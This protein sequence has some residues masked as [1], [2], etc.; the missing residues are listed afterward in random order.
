VPG[1][2]LGTP[3]Y[4]S[5]EQCRGDEQLDHRSDVYALGVVLY[6]ML[7]GE[8]PF[9]GD[10]LFQ[11]LF[12]QT[13]ATPRPPRELRPEITD[14][15]QTVVQI[16]LEK[17]P[18]QRFTGMDA[19]REAL[20]SDGPLR[21][22][23]ETIAATVQAK[24][25]APALAKASA[26]AE[27]KVEPEL[28]PEQIKDQ[29]QRVGSRLARI[30]VERIHKDKLVLPNLPTVA[31]ECIALLDDPDGGMT[32]V[33]M[34]IGRDP[35]VA[36]QVLRRARSAMMGGGERVRTIEHAVARLGARQLRALLI[37]LS[38]RRL[39]E[40]RDPA[41]RR[42]TRN[43]WEHSV[44]VAV[45]ARALARRR[46]DVDS[47]VA[48]LAGLLH[49]VGKP[50]AAALLLEAERSTAARDGAWLGSAA[51]LG[52]IDECHREVGVAMARSWGL[53]DEVIFAMA[54]CDRYSA[55]GA[56]SPASVVCF[57]NALVKRQGIYCGEADAETVA[58]L[59]REGQRLYKLD[60][61]MVATLTTELEADS[62]QHGAAAG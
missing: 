10:T 11:V 18:Q 25:S 42:A 7:T 31:T 2:I 39:F 3:H 6:R 57:A 49:D 43:L 30:L 14:W 19:M 53:P 58:A 61:A 48:Y 28:E 29:S 60:D 4:M 41:I 59:I 40:S 23:V 16:A 1:T 54:R 46:R 9:D 17:N 52:V 32:K 26:E 5:P 62:N 45:V 27:A 50:V 55:E 34:V 24:D 47:D 13:N 56:G 51:W 21:S 38:A 44:A 8:L 12:A 35:I 15:A 37:E 36:P 22:S 33:A 20:E